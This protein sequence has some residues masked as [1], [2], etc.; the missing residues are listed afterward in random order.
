MP[1]LYIKLFDRVMIDTYI[2]WVLNASVASKGPLFH[3]VLCFFTRSVHDTIT[4]DVYMI[5]PIGGKVQS[6]QIH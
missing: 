6:F 5:I 2:Q 3:I 4:S 1:L